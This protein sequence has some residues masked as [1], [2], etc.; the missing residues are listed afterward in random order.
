MVVADI[1]NW[2]ARRYPEKAAVV[3][4]ATRYTFK[5][6][7]NRVNSLISALSDM[8]VGK[9][10]RMAILAD[11]CPQYM[12]TYFAGA[13]G[14]IAIVPLNNRLGSND[15]CYI[16]NNSEANTLIFGENYLHVVDSIRPD[17]STVRNFI[18]IG[19]ASE[20]MKSYEGLVSSYPPN[21][22]KVELGEGDLFCILYTSGT[23]G[24]PKG[25]MW[26]H[27]NMVAAVTGLVITVQAAHDDIFLDLLP[28]FSVGSILMRL[29]YSYMG[30]TNV[31]VM[32]ADLKSWLEAIEGERVTSCFLSPSLL[33][34]F[35][36]YPDIGKYDLASLRL[37]WYG[38]GSLAT[39][40]LKRAIGFF[41]SIIL[42]VYGLTEGSLLTY[43]SRED[44]VLQGTEEK[45]RRLRSC[46]RE[47]VNVE[48]RIIDEEGNEVAPGEVGEL[49]ARG[50]NIVK[51]YWK[52]PGPT[53]DTFRGG[54]LYTSDLATRDEEGYIYFIGTP[55]IKIISGG[56]KV[57][58]REVEDVIY[59]HPSVLET[60]V[61]GIPDDK[62]GESVKAI[63]VLKEGMKATEEEIIEFCKR[64]LASY[65]VPQSVEFID[66]LP[67]TPSGKVL[68]RLLQSS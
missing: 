60:V 28:L 48:I 40:V 41:G 9:G 10:D 17:L 16:V 56:E 31:L 22:P 27:K 5:Q 15:L 55:K 3:C 2:N 23:T 12:E 25:A 18:N 57:Y 39:E 49:I 19:A 50:D 64:S 46:G 58:S 11:D 66:K 45:I 47:V 68:K 7:N 34:S 63:V 36:E 8:G 33:S 65:A 59:A 44:H 35:L 51:G 61:I 4:G 62:L 24:L 26:T 52:L 20:G 54:Y 53:A 13:K 1:I 29:G 21:E 14:G 32:K 43:L 30:C 37:L 38:G 6:L 67:R 42:Q